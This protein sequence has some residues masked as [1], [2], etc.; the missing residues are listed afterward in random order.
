MLA[1]CERSGAGGSFAG[2]VDIVKTFYDLA[3]EAL[4]KVKGN[5][6][7]RE[8]W[9]HQGRSIREESELIAQGQ[10]DPDAPEEKTHLGRE[11]GQD[12]AFR[13][14]GDRAFFQLY[15]PKEQYHLIKSSTLYIVG[16]EDG[17]RIAGAEL[18][19]RLKAAGRIAEYSEHP[20][21]DHG[22]YWGE[23]LD[24]NGHVP[25]EFYRSL[26]RTTGFLGKWVKEK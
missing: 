25:E 26:K 10:I 7:W 11:V 4:P 16:N 21:M 9:W 18:V 23:K 22:F 1:T 2:L 20:G 5:Y 15:S 24:V 6:E 14:G 13:Y 19:D 12:V 17:C 8:R 3:Q